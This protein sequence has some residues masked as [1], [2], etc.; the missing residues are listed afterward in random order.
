MLQTW[1]YSKE[2]L[3]LQQ[4]GERSHIKTVAPTRN[5][6]LCVIGSKSHPDVWVVLH[7]LAHPPKR[8]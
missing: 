6:A 1:A 3:E 2:A 5:S 7:R 4:R 8:K